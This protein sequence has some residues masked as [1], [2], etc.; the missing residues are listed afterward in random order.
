MTLVSYKIV[1][2]NY[3]KVAKTLKLSTK[4]MKFDLIKLK[5]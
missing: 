5:N 3:R 4:M 2:I 1:H